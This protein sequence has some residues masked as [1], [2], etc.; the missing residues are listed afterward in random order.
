M[1]KSSRQELKNRRGQKTHWQRHNWHLTDLSTFICLRISH[2]FGYSFSPSWIAASPIFGILLPKR[3]W[4]FPL[5][6]IQSNH[7]RATH[8]EKSVVIWTGLS[9]W[10]KTLPLRFEKN[11]FVSK[12]TICTDFLLGIDSD[13]RIRTIVRRSFQVCLFAI[14]FVD[15]LHSTRDYHFRLLDAKFDGYISGVVVHIWQ[16]FWDDSSSLGKCY[17][18]YH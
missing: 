11:A 12:E 10:E 18:W 5:T 15:M 16:D 13:C 6:I 8:T 4:F 9:G 14:K 1:E 7:S 17:T 2:F 3:S